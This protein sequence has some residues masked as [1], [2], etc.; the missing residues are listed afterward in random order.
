MPRVH[1][2]ANTVSRIW[3]AICVP[4]VAKTS[5]FHGSE[6]ATLSVD[7]GEDTNKELRAFTIFAC[8]ACGFPGHLE[9]HFSVIALGGLPLEPWDVP[10][11]G[12]SL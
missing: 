8:L 10:V 3:G 7:S 4:G 6:F 1:V 9:N 11:T 2:L 5:R 12:Y